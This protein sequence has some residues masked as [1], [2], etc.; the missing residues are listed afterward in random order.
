MAAS[1]RS[2]VGA[3]RRRAA[4]RTGLRGSP[5]GLGRA[6]AGR[7]AAAFR[8]RSGFPSTKA[9]RGPGGRRR[10]LGASRRAAHRTP[11]RVRVRGCT[12]ALDRT[13][14]EGR[15]RAGAPRQVGLR[16]EG[17]NAARFRDSRHRAR[18]LRARRRETE[19]ARDGSVRRRALRRRT[20][21]RFATHG[22]LADRGRIDP[23][24]GRVGSSPRP[25]PDAAPRRRVPA[26][27]VWAPG[28]LDRR[29]VAPPAAVEQ[30]A[31]APDDSTAD[32]GGVVTPSVIAS[33]GP[34]PADP[35]VR[36]GRPL[37]R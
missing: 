33:V 1:G 5:V 20:A 35:L 37:G 29:A 4:S 9:C 24:R 14:P 7:K 26:V 12:P 31:V 6:G 21:A 13:P 16:A 32:P 30:A 17:A 34:G 3:G 2:P 8:V 25:L 36:S 19:P 11:R 10:S 18:S 23:G 15:P 22:A 27:T 28:R